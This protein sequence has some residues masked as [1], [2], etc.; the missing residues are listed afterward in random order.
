MMHIWFNAITMP[1]NDMDYS[2]KTYSIN[3]MGSISSH[4]MLLVI[5]ILRVDTRTHTHTDVRD[6]VN[7]SY[8]PA[9]GISRRVQIYN[10]IIFMCASIYT[11]HSLYW[12]T[13]YIIILEQIENTIS[14][15]TEWQ[16][17]ENIICLCSDMY[18]Y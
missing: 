13:Y 11:C 18:N 17:E 16:Y 2:C 12:C 5:N 3:Y 7:F 10:I 15:T 4:I 1:T 6:T 14:C 8:V 9:C